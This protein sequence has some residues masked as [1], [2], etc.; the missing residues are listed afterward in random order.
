MNCPRCGKPVPNDSI[1]CD[2]CGMILNNNSNSNSNNNFNDNNRPKFN[3]N[4]YNQNNSYAGYNVPVTFQE[5]LSE[6]GLTEDEIKAFVGPKNKAYYMNSFNKIKTSKNYNVI[7]FVSNGARNFNLGKI[8]N[9][10]WFL[11][12]KMFQEFAI[13]L[14]ILIAASIIKDI[15]GGL[16]LVGWIFSLVLGLIPLTMLI[17]I[18]IYGDQMY[19]DFVIK[20]VKQIKQMHGN[21]PNYL[22][23]LSSFGGTLF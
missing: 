23:I 4:N 12:R 2:N 16:F 10:W 19:R 22:S 15:F 14:V 8:F 1:L 18:M 9:I 21:S 13:G 11:Y 7:D 6:N 17:L 5:L 20:R 3:Q